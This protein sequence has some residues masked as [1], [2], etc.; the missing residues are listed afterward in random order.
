MVRGRSHRSA[1]SGPLGR[2]TAPLRA[3]GALVLALSVAGL[4]AA[5][6][7]A[8]A[9]PEYRNKVGVDL[10]G[11][12]DRGKE[13]TDL[14]RTLRPWETLNADSCGDDQAC[15]R[16]PL[17]A[18]GWPTTDA[19]TVF[20]DVRPFGAWWGYNQA[21]CP[22]C[23]DGTFIPDMSGTYKLSFNGQAEL[24]AAEGSVNVVG[25]RY[26]AATNRTT[27]DIVVQ[28]GEGLL[29]VQFVNTRRTASSA[30]NTGITNLKLI[31][32]GFPAD[33]S[34][35]FN[36]RFIDALEPFSTLRF[37]NWVG[38]NN[39]NP[40]FSAA[41]NTVDW[42]E[43]TQPTDLQPS[44]EG[45]AWEH[46]VAVANAA[47]KDVWINVP[48]HASPDYIR[49]LAQFMRANLHR[50]ARVYVES[51]NE[52]WNGLFAQANYNRDQ[53][54]AEVLRNPASPLAL[55]A[56]ANTTLNGQ[57]YNDTWRVRNHMRRLVEI[58]QIFGDV[59]G[60][61]QINK[62]VRVIHAW[63]IGYYP[64]GIQYA[65]QLDWVARVYGAP[66]DYLYAVAGAAYFNLDQ[67][68][69]DGNPN[70]ATTDEII[71]A[72]RHNS[73]ES[74]EARAQLSAVGARYGLKHVMYEGGPD[75]AGPL[76]WNRSTQLLERINAVQRSPVM[77]DLILHDMRDNWFD[78]P[79]IDGDLFIFF[80]LQSAFSRWGH[81]GL[82]ET[83]DDLNTPKM[84][85]I[86]ELTHTR[87]KQ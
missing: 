20:F 23:A 79:A 18:E 83:I 65:E 40:A 41:D 87:V 72:L 58:S 85:A 68:Y 48:I 80:T 34:V 54:Q 26:D 70:D 2:W 22:L 14:A 35:V 66:R 10:G 36:P 51:S 57:P 82:T 63:Q 43:R 30:T 86:Y 46:V 16:A 24:R 9:A 7:P 55:D 44:G 33:G 84:Q 6:Q 17:D 11:I 45:V 52:V 32:P 47:K 62:R 27:A 56:P 69:A 29:F 12:N 21:G 73:D 1:A 78:D 60:E 13:F 15:R 28:R 37:M 64:V 74:A 76:Q 42:A 4:G 49:G 67:L 59:Y 77:R 19:R 39:I 8:A 50:D 81:W 25:Q 61:S 53:A 31:R 5:P 75:T 3:A 71:A 38:G